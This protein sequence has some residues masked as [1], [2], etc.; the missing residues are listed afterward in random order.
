MKEYLNNFYQK[1]EGIILGI[2]IAATV[3]FISWCLFTDIQKI[4]EIRDIREEIR[5][6]DTLIQTR[7]DTVI[8]NVPVPYYIEKNN[9]DT[10]LVETTTHDTVSVPLPKI[11]KQYQDSTY[12]ATVSGYYD[13]NLDS[14]QTYKQ[15]QTIKI[16]EQITKYKN[17]KFVF[18]PAISVGYDPIKK[19]CSPTIGI[20]LTYNLLQTK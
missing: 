15:T 6:I 8:Y 11:I 17:P 16:T 2:L 9:N 19:Q 7:T 12:K 3:F 1:Y 5:V 4:R 18:G 20:S 14:I 13:V 10:I